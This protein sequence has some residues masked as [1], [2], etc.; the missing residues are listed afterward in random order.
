M[1]GEQS[2]ELR[3]KRRSAEVRQLIRMQFDRKS[4]RPRRPKH[5]RRLISG[6]AMPSIEGVDGVC[7]AGLRHRREHLAANKVDVSILV[8]IGFGRQRMRAKKRRPD[9]DRPVAANRACG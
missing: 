5:P 9:T 2:R 6:K 3:S 4:K 8:A 1:I 7:K